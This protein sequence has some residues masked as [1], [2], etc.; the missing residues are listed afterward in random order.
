M[1]LFV[2][3][4]AG[5]ADDFVVSIY[6]DGQSRTFRTSG[7]TVGSVLERA[8]VVVGA[9]D[10]VEPNV[11]TELKGPVYNV[12]IFRARPVYVVD[13]LKSYV[14]NS[15][16]SS[17]KLIAEDVGLEVYPEDLL[18][19][20]RVDDFVG[21]GIIGEQLIITRAIPVVIDLYGKKIEHRTHAKTIGELLAEKSI[22]PDSEDYVSLENNVAVEVGTVVSV[23]RVGQLVELVEEEISYE[24]EVI[25]DDSVAYGYESIEQVGVNGERTVTYEVEYHNGLE[26][27]RKQI[28]AVVSIEPVTQVVRVGMLIPDG[29]ENRVL[30][31]QLAEAN[32]WEGEQWICLLHLWDKESQWNHLA[33]NPYSSAYGIPQFLDGTWAGTGY[34]KSSDASTQILAGMAY[35]ENRYGTP[36]GAWQ[37]SAEFN[38][39]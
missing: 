9:D 22:I 29:I 38:W 3:T 25:W 12:N 14:V 39:Y 13:G 17:S 24:T 32:G 2:P 1:I 15:P 8:G 23:I 36:C 10:L 19:L 31:Q 37:H 6:S 34:Q 27:E 26:V 20:S 11:E 35:I 33:Q 18:E 30:G 5:A 16:Y 4:R 7:G 21:A 28:K